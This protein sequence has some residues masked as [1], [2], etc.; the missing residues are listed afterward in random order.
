[1]T[2]EHVLFECD[3][4]TLAGTLDRAEGAVGILIV[5][6]GNEIR[7]GAFAGQSRLAETIVAKGYPVFRFD[8]RGVGDSEGANGGFRSSAPDIGAALACFREHCA[9]IKRVAAFGNCDAASALMLLGGAGFDALALA[10]PWTFDDESAGEMPADLVRS[11]YAS[12]LADPAE[13]KRLLTGGVSLAKLA[14]GLV[15]ST[16][17]AVPMS[18]LG[19]EMHS[20]MS[21]YEG[22]VRYLVAGRD[23]TGMAFKAAWPGADEIA[24]NSSADHGFSAMQDREWLEREL[25]SVLEE[26]ARQLDMG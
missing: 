26:Q 8:R 10:N 2:R 9:Q 22:S 17:R 25:L 4:S 3:G 11:R 18:G 21:G 6:G 5:S 13:W 7:S 1:M 23:R 12:K 24:V 19:Q 15:R 14:K 20:A 16:R